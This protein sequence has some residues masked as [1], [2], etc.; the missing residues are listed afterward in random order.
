MVRAT[1]AD[2]EFSTQTF[3]IDVGDTNEIPTPTHEGGSG[4]DNISGGSGND[5]IF[6]YDGQ[7]QVYGGDGDDHI[8]GGND[9]DQLYGDA[10]NDTLDGG[11]GNDQI[12][13]GSGNDVIYGQAGLD[14]IYG[15]AGDDVIDGGSG[16]DQLYGGDGA[17]L[18]LV[19]QGN[20]DDWIS[21]G[22]GGG[23]TDVIEL[24]DAAGGSNIG[25]YGSDWTVALTSGS[26]ESSDTNPTDGWLD[27]TDD[28]AGTITLQDGTQIE[29]EG[30]E[31]IQ[32]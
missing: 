23:W 4:D 13:G 21:G 27:L 28:A 26:I 14:Q 30:I 5:A 10:G 24:Q 16:N 20:G 9:S 8:Y 25:T 18:F 3:T 1:G 17:D 19:L 22:N 29:F 2:G 15:E 32:W 31:H 6:G 7:D 11:S 12:Y